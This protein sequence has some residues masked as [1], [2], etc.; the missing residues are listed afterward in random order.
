[1]TIFLAIFSFSAENWGTV[2]DW[3][4]VCVTIITAIFLLITLISQKKVQQT[5]NELFRIESIRFRESIKP[6]FKYSASTGKMKPG[7]KD[8]QVLTVEVT[9]ESNSM[10]LNISKI[11][12]QNERTPQIFVI[13]GFTDRIDHLS[14][15]D[16][17]LIF[18]FLIDATPKFQNFVTFALN[19]QDIAGANYKQGVLCICDDLGIEIN[20]FLPEI[21]L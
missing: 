13:T 2:S 3:V 18:H 17:P 12:S 4:M 11:V 16:N 1:M 10:A 5:Q 6:K 7:D 9:N 8:K 19:Y 20:P 15:G 21:I 14:K